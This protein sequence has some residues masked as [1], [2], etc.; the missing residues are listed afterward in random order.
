MKCR[1]IRAL[2]EDYC[3]GEI[4]ES[5]AVRSHLETCAEC[6]RYCEAL[7]AE[8]KLYQDY[9]KALDH[10]LAMSPA[11][12]QKVRASLKTQPIHERERRSNLIWTWAGHFRGPALLRQAI[13]AAVI[14]IL[15]VGGTLLAVRYFQAQKPASISS[16]LKTR[17]ETGKQESPDNLE[18]AI[19]LIQ[20]AEWEYMTAIN[21]LSEIVDKRKPSLDPGILV[22]YEK[23]LKAINE[24]IASARMAYHAHPDDPELA[25]YML[26]AYERK[27]DLLLEIAS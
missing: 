5:S 14:V 19:R 11:A 27:V 2:L 21:V 3:R 23:N 4:K 15:S 10:Q 26:M 22:K 25:Y 7:A 8:D 12:W 9:C 16:G 18:G 20:R 13:F 1:K 24:S 6:R 17:P